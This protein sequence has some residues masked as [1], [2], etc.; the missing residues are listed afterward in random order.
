[1][2]VLT[3]NMGPIETKPQDVDENKAAARFEKDRM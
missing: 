1:M 2:Y 3:E